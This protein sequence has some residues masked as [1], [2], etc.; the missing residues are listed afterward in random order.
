[1]R[2]FQGVRR[3]APGALS[4]N[5]ERHGAKDLRFAFDLGMALGGLVCPQPAAA[6]ACPGLF[7]SGPAGTRTAIW[8]HKNFAQS[9]SD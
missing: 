8:R 6:S 1:L 4:R 9:L 7:L 5:P 2:R 3:I